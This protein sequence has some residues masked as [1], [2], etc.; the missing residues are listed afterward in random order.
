MKS[1]TKTK[2]RRALILIGLLIGTII[3]VFFGII[4][5]INSPEC[6]ERET[7]TE[8]YIY[9]CTGYTASGTY[10]CSGSSWNASCYKEDVEIQPIC[11]RIP[12]EKQII[13]EI[14]K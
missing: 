4:I 12:Y 10:T 11:E 9:E 8:V 2:E 7:T 13:K 1:Q 5:V 3:G 14:K 6:S